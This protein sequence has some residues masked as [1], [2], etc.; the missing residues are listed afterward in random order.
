MATCI[1]TNEDCGD[2]QQ[3]TVDMPDRLGQN[4]SPETVHV[5]P[6]H[7]EDVRRYVARVRA[8]GT[9]MIGL[10]F[11]LALVMVGAA[12]LPT[13]GADGAVPPVSAVA[14]ML[15]G[16]VIYWFP[17][18][19]PETVDMLGIHRSVSMTQWIALFMQVTGLIAFGLA[20][21]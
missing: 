17:F 20:F 2:V 5:C 4:P 13:V 10:V 12:F 6:E 9:T 3:I 15:M 14:S 16:A 21:V 11:G 18:A 8:H 1:W 7:E 19:T